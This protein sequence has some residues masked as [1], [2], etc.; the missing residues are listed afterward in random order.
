MAAKML[1]EENKE[2]VTYFTHAEQKKLTNT[3]LDFILLNRAKDGEELHY[4]KI[5]VSDLTTDAKTAHVGVRKGKANIWLET[6]TLTT[7]ATFYSPTR[8]IVVTENNRLVVGFVG[9]SANDQCVVNVNG[10][11]V[12]NA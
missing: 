6:L 10:Y 2:K 3:T 5:G 11:R 9:I 4:E 8:K 1:S 12:K 7:K